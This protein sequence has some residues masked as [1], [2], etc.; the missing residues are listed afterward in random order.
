MVAVSLKNQNAGIIYQNHFRNITVN[1]FSGF[2]RVLYERN[3]TKTTTIDG[4]DIIIKAAK[5]GS[6]LILRTSH[7]D[8]LDVKAQNE[9]L[10]NLATKLQYTGEKGKLTG[11]VE[12]AEGLMEAK[13]SKD[14]EFQDDGHGKYIPEA[15]SSHESQISDL[16][17]K[18]DNNGQIEGRKVDGN[19]SEIYKNLNID[20]SGSSIDE[21]GNEYNSVNGLY[22]LHGGKVDV[23]GNATITVKNKKPASRGFLKGA[24][25]AHYYMSGIYAGYGGVTNDGSY[26][27]CI[28]NIAGNADIDAIGVGLQANKDSFITIKGGGNIKTYALS[29]SATYAM[30]A[31]E[32][33]VFMN[34]GDKGT[35]PGE[36]NV[37]IYGNLGIIDKNYGIDPNPENHGSFISVGLTTENSKFTGGILN[38]FEEN[39]ENKYD[40][41]IDLYLKNKAVWDNQ[42]IG[43]YR[44]VVNNDNLSGYTLRNNPESYLYKGSKVR[45]LIGG[46]SEAKAGIIYQ[47]EDKDITVKNFSGHVKV[48]YKQNATNA[49]AFDGGA[50]RIKTAKENSQITLRSN[51][52]DFQMPQDREVVNYDEALNA[53]AGKLFY[54]ANDGHLKGIVEFAETLD[55]PAYTKEISFKSDT[56]QG[57]YK[58]KTTP[59]VDKWA[60]AK[61]LKRRSA[62]S[63][64]GYWMMDAAKKMEYPNNLVIDILGNGKTGSKDAQVVT[65]IYIL[66][67][68][69]FILGKD[70]KVIVQNPNPA[71]RGVTAGAD[72]AHYYMNAIYAGY[73]T[74]DGGGSGVYVKGDVDIDVV[75]TGLQ[76]NRFSYITVKGGGKIKTHIIPTSETYAMLAEEGSVFMNT[77]DKGNEPGTS[78]VDIYGNLG[79]IN[80][81]YGINPN[82]GERG[83][84]VSLGLTTENSRFT[85]GILNE[86]EENGENKHDSGIDLY[87]KNKAV[88][89]NQWIGTYR[90]AVNNDNANHNDDDETYEQRKNPESYLYKGSKVR[91]LI[92]GESEEKAGIIYQN[93]DKDITVKNFSGHVKVIYKQNAANV[94]AFDGG[95]IRI[96]TAKENSQITLRSNIKDFQMPQDREVVNYDEALNALAGKLFYDANDGH[97]KGIVEFAETLDKPAYTKEI[98]F[99]SDTHQGEYKSKI[100]PPPV[101]DTEVI[102][103]V[104]DG[105]AV[106]REFRDG[107]QTTFDKDV[108]VNVSGK[109]ISGG[110]NAQNV[111]GIYILNNSKVNFNKN[112]KITVK[113]ADPA[114]RGTSE[115][116]DVAHY[117][118]SGIYVGYGSGGYQYSQAL[119]KGNVDIDVVGVGIQ[120]NKDGYIYVDGGGNITTHALTGS[121][122]YALLSEEGMV[123]MNVKFDSEGYLLGAGNH[124]VNVYGNLGIL[125]KNYGIDP[126]PGAKES[127]IALGLATANSKLTG[128]VLNEFDENGNNTNESGVDLYLQNGA[129][130]INRWIGA[131]RV[132]APRKDAETYLFKGSKVHNFYGGKT[133]AETGFIEQ[134]DGDRPI[135]IE[136]Y[137]GY[138]VVKYAH[139]GKGKI[140]GGDIRIEEAFDGSGISIRTKSLNGLKVGTTVADDQTLINK[141]LAA[142][143]QKLVYQADDGKLKAKVEIAEGLATPSI[144]KAITYFDE[145]HHGVYDPTGVVPKKPK[146]FEKHTQGAA[147]GHGIYDDQKE[148]YDDVII[149]VSG[150]GVTSEKTYNNVVGLYVLDGGQADIKG[151]LKVTVKNPRPA[152]R[153]SSEGADIAH[154]YM[155]GVYAGYGGTTGDGDHGNSIVNVAGNVDLDVVGVA[156]QA[157]KDGYITVKGGGKIKTYEIP[158]SETYAMLAEEGSVFM[159]TGDKGNTPGTSDVDIYGNLGVINKNYGI[160][161][162]PGKHESIVSVGLTTGKSKFTGGILNEFEENG[163]NKHDSGVDLYLQNGATWENH[164]IGTH[165]AK[166]TVP[167]KNSESYLYKGS[168]VRNLIGGESEAK[169]GIIYQNEDKDITVKNFSGH[170]K[171]IYKQNAANVKAFDGGAIRIKT[172]KENSQITLRSNIKDFQMPQDREVVNYDEALNALAGKLFYDA[173]DG[174]LKGIVEFAETLDKPAYTK[175]ISFKSDTHQG[176][177]KP[178]TTPPVVPPVTPS[179]EGQTGTEFDSHSARIDGRSKMMHR[180]DV[181]DKNKVLTATGEYTFT[182]DSHLKTKSITSADGK[183]TINA[184][185]KVLTLDSRDEFGVQSYVRRSSGSTPK[186]PQDILINAKKIVLNIDQ[187]ASTL[188]ARDAFGITAASNG[189]TVTI[190]G[191]AEVHV[192]NK[193]DKGDPTGRPTFTNGIATLYHGNIKINGSVDVDVQAPG[194]K[195]MGEIAFLNHYFINGIFAGLNADD[196]KMGSTVYIR[197]NAN[198]K[199]NGTAIHAGINTSV[200]IGG[201]GDVEITKHDDIAQFAMNAEGGIINM[202]VILDGHGDAIGAGHV[203]TNIKGNIG[204]INREDDMKKDK[205]LITPTAVRLGLTT[206]ESQF[207]GIIHD[208]FKEGNAEQKEELKEVREK[209]GVTLY[210]QNGATW[211]NE[212]WGALIADSWNNASHKFTGSKVAHLIG[213]ETPEKAGVIKQ[214][215]TRDITI[216][217]YS[218]HVKVL[219]E[220]NATNAKAFDGGA[221]RIKTA[222]ENSQITLRSNIR[223]FQKPSGENADYDAL[224]N[225]L[226]GKLYYEAKDNHLTAQAEIAESLATPAYAK[227]ISFKAADGQGEVK[228][229]TTQGQTPGQGGTTPGQTPGQG[230]TTP[231]QTP[232][233]GGTTPGQTPGQGGTTPGQDPNFE[234]SVMKGIRSTMVS[235]GMIST[236]AFWSAQ[237]NDVERRMGDIRL[238]RTE[239]GLWAKYQGGSSEYNDTDS[240]E[241]AVHVDQ[242]YNAIQVGYD[243][244]VGDW[245]V[246]GTFSYGTTK[247]KYIDNRDTGKLNGTGKETGFNGGVYGTL[248]QKDGSYFDIIAKVGQIKNN[249]EVYTKDWDKDKKN[250]DKVNSEYKVNGTSLS[251]EYGKRIEREGFYVEPSM[252]LTVNRVVGHSEEVTS[253]VHKYKM[254]ITQDDMTS[255]VG[256]IG[257]GIGQNY[258]NGHI[259]GKLSLAHEFN[260]D[261]MTTFSAGNKE[262]V[263]KLSLRGTWLDVEMGGSY[264]LSKDSYFY[265]SFTKNFGAK[266]N[267]KWRLDAGIR[268]AF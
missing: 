172:A 170:V 39:G 225:T 85:G 92:G 167:R 197:D 99:K 113:N 125:N 194:Q 96:K 11:T 237:N 151:N 188:S 179:V 163:E 196:D 250:D 208:D 89:N 204:L 121:D 45:N 84:F 24:D 134:E 3:K 171:V 253:E 169:A 23:K 146:K 83:S 164:W 58:P 86:F 27:N 76:A 216:Y 251:V 30:L 189:S 229:G 122:T 159:N 226:A 255:V 157:N 258:E 41:G 109:G 147:T 156:L 207:K 65:G 166:A 230:G 224:L 105:Y 66:N 130:W 162:N 12:I 252:E 153:G 176:E 120:A 67:N 69:K 263:V 249:Y 233:E 183:V 257:V 88:W 10:S 116:A 123:A 79:V 137:N 133:E 136:H 91:N 239:T 4:G 94:K 187:V 19:K 110:K 220:Q 168:K 117:Y 102:E 139:D 213:G 18:K 34:T 80:K 75:G 140:Q 173:N 212:T 63:T 32:G 108:V 93:E 51:I 28:V 242:T 245:I 114:T 82:P 2:V 100:T 1:N 231:G 246:G 186:E 144:S 174:H 262:E 152:L 217:D 248:K 205:R 135:D 232:G 132:K 191:D 57:E 195:N 190:N 119:I 218:G 161:P 46:E 26:D 40:S 77:G 6:H 150:S 98:S 214:D 193:S 13:I 200:T 184:A 70:L 215:D 107:T 182:K 254:K 138:T 160:D 14:I 118:M 56:H 227:K 126:N 175:E 106:G 60:S 234:T 228:A 203:R 49:K 55:K 5:E 78:D 244:S 50:I 112:L 21:Y 101:Q 64:M 54:D 42:W 199:T 127:Y 62:G 202:N 71:T 59:P 201:G 47:N 143:A 72:V 29:T 8:G 97:L 111:T 43:S 48:I 247:D 25:L 235:T 38:E 87:L 178:K 158:T 219:Y 211:I 241:K 243:K 268:L 267:N 142:L 22:V 261:I 128:A 37:N 20:V 53:L 266:L 31:E 90:V 222:K 259:Y 141:T 17:I 44:P 103:K 73:G 185:G 260:G 264:R 115:G 68:N 210:L 124:D 9:T 35:T 36:S 221:I 236:G 180:R 240:R 256:R 104:T 148:S 145:N 16:N 74:L 265:G 154:Y 81:N 61:V 129:T 198:V 181:F 238:A 15:D 223:D 209:S 165:R 95:A 131:E 33:S 149:N 206:E 52:K 155:S 7:V 192:K 177:Y